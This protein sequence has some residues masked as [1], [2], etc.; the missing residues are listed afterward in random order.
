MQFIKDE[1]HQDYTVTPFYKDQQGNVGKLEI[2]EDGTFKLGENLFQTAEPF[3]LSFQLE[4]VDEVQHLAMFKMSVKNAIGNGSSP[5]PEDQK[6]W[7]EYVDDEVA[8]YFTANF[9][10]KL[11]EFNERYEEIKK[12]SCRWRWRK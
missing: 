3:Y 9:Q 4:K 6:L 12:N 8:K 5:L 11:D 2:E 10:P 1:T 7:I